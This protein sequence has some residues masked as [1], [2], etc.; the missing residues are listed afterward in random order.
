MCT[1]A[2]GIHGVCIQCALGIHSVSGHICYRQIHVHI[3]YMISLVEG[4]RSS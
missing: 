2:I 4:P 3:M 1:C